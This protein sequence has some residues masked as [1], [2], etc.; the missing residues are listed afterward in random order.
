MMK[1]FDI[2]NSKLIGPITVV[3]ILGL[4]YWLDIILISW[5][6]QAFQTFNIKPF[7][8]F[9]I[10]LLILFAILVIFLAWLLLIYSQPSWVTLV[11]CLL[12]DT[13]ILGL[14][15]FFIAPPGFLAS[16]L[17]HPAITVGFYAISGRGFESI[18]LR[19]GAFV[20]VIG[21]V[22]LFCKIRETISQ[23]NGT[24]LRFWRS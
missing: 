5:R 18:T 6:R 16:I 7:F 3:I 22:S 20:L 21:L 10:A 9:N 24:N 1:T 12:T 15:V 17:N 14:Q 8:Y 11:F 13:I 19:A 2:R 23:N 4:M